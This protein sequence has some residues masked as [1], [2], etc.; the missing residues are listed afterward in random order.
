MTGEEGLS[1]PEG[2]VRLSLTS[3]HVSRLVCYFQPSPHPPLPPRSGG[4][5]DFSRLKKTVPPSQPSHVS[6]GLRVLLHAPF[7]LAPFTMSFLRA[8]ALTASEPPGT[9]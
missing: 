4:R 9:Y 1:S 2:L 8:V 7:P 5:A 3:L 6:S